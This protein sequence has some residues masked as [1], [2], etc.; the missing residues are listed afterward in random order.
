MRAQ[1]DADTAILL[2]IQSVNAEKIA[3]I[4]KLNELHLQIKEELKCETALI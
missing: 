3:K 1:A 4:I 2:V